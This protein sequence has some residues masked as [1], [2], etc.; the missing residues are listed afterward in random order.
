MGLI[1]SALVKAMSGAPQKIFSS[2]LDVFWLFY[3]TLKWKDCHFF[4]EGCHNL[5]QLYVKKRSPNCGGKEGV[6]ICQIKNVSFVA[7]SWFKVR[8]NSLIW[9]NV[10]N[11]QNLCVWPIENF[12]R[13]SEVKVFA[14]NSHKMIEYSEAWQ[15]FRDLNFKNPLESH[16]SFN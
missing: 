9:E 2:N 14:K 7:R 3:T 11:T 15:S 16:F 5:P 4:G 8:Y 13:A 10:L 1:Q 6:T 12:L